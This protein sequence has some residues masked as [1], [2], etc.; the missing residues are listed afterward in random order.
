MSELNTEEQISEE[1]QRKYWELSSFYHHVMHITNHHPDT[2]PSDIINKFID[3]QEFE[4]KA[5][6]QMADYGQEMW[7]H[8]QR[9]LQA[10]KKVKG[11]TFYKYLVQIIK[12]SDRV[13]EKMEIVKE[14]CGTWQDEPFGR[15]IKGYWVEQWSVGTEGDSFEGFVCVQIKENKYL[16]F[17]YSM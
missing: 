17:R 15:T 5:W 3:N 2:C 11:K 4:A 10:I 7:Q 16:K 9:L 1:R 6:Q 13:T 12:D 14:P 8:N